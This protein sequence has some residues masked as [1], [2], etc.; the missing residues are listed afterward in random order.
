MDQK[1]RI[2]I[3]GIGNM[4]STH[5][6]NIVEGKVPRLSLTAV[7]DNNPDRLEW[8]EK[9]LPETVARFSDAGELMNSGLV[10]AVLIA[11]PHYFHPPFAIMAMEKGLHV[12][13]E[14]PAGVYTKQVREMNGV[15][16]VFNQR[17]I[18]VYLKMDELV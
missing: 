2:G 5:D 18:C 17:S 12:L 7:A 4:G 10:D 8:A 1:V 14:K 15:A 13:C 11:V 3:I 6:K 16:K 9:P